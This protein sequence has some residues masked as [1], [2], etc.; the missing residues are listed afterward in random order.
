MKVLDVIPSPKKE[1]THQ[2]IVCMCQG[3]S[4]CSPLERKYVHY[5]SDLKH[6]T[7]EQYQRELISKKIL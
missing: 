2:A 3:N 1:A 7:P 4:K 5:N 6:G